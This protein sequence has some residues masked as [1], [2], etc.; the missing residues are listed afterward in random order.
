VTSPLRLILGLPPLAHAAVGAFAVYLAE[1]SLPDGWPG[2]G[3][4]YGVAL[5]F[6]LAAVGRLLVPERDEADTPAAQMR[7]VDSA[8]EVARRFPRPPGRAGRGTAEPDRPGHVPADSPIG[9]LRGR[10]AP[11]EG[12]EG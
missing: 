12:G 6:A 2:R 10:G 7:R 9:R 5:V 4:W 11:P 3:G 8:V 1:T